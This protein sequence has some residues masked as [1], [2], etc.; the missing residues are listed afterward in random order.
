M[1][2]CLV[3]YGTFLDP[4]GV[5][6]GNS[7]RAY[8]L[9]RG[10][11]ERGVEVVHFY[12]SFLER[13][14]GADVR[15]PAGVTV[16][17]YTDAADLLAQIDRERPTAVLVGYWELLEHFPEGYHLPLIVDVVAPRILESLFEATR[18]LSAEAA[19]IV[20]LYRR[21]D[22]FLAGNE[23]Q[24]SFLVPWLILAGFRCAAGVPVAVVP[25]ST[26]VDEPPAGR[27]PGNDWRFVSGGV[28]WPWR[29]IEP[30]F[31]PL[32]AA[33]GRGPARLELF[34]GGYVYAGD[35]APRPAA[36]RWPAELVTVRELR[37]YAEMHAF[38]ASSCHV[39][40]ELAE[41]NLERE[42]SQSFRSADFLRHGLPLLCNRYLELARWIA[43]YDAGWVVDA[44][45]EVPAALD[46]IFAA[47]EAWRAKSENARRL[48]RE[49]LHYART[50]EPVLA[51]LTA[52]QRPERGPRALLG[53]P[54]AGPVPIMAAA[55]VE[56]AGRTLAARVPLRRRVRRGLRRAAAAVARAVLPRGGDAVLVVTRDDVFPANHGAAVKIDRTAS[57]LSA[58]VSAVYLATENRERY[59]RYR[60]GTVE[61]LRYPWPLRRVGPRGERVR[62][63][64]LAAGVPADDAFLYAARY[65]W[66]FA[67][68]ALYLALRHGAR[69]YQAEFPAYAKATLPARELLGGVTA[70]V[71]HNVE[72]Q[73]LADQNRDLP[74]RAA[75][76]LRGIELGLCEA[77]DFVV[78]VSARDRDTL[79]RD[80]VPPGNVRVIPHG[81]DLR[82][83]AAAVATRGE[84]RR[85]LGIG[86]AVPLLVFHGVYLYPPNLEA[87][88]VL[89]REILPRLHERGIRPKV[90]A[91]GPYPPAETPH[92]DI[93]FT[94][95]VPDVAPFLLDA[96]VA[97]VPLRRGGGTRM[98]VLDY[99]AAGLPV[100]ST[101]KGVEGLALR[102][103]EHALIRDDGA[104]FAA[105]VAELLDSPASRAALGAA[106]RR[107][108]EP[109]DWTAISARY[110]EA[111]RAVEEARAGPGGRGRLP[112]HE[113]ESA[114]DSNAPGQA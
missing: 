105:A 102:D 92:P 4:T 99:F 51:F 74:E 6:S 72:Y 49:R 84:A 103:G 32:V 21:A 93:L 107:F 41:Y 85:R 13:H 59:Y 80:G 46:R 77:A 73:R 65:D 98:K 42:F 29:R 17:S 75:A 18:D 91:I 114:V 76:W 35:E 33:L 39:G 25:I 12:P 47:P 64:L 23:R 68:R 55:P 36:P 50:I 57:G 43:E 48:A 54:S 90:L 5:M 44:P 38:L 40:V 89:A 87:M 96:D 52:P 9:A 109:L 2:T 112:A 100:V 97:V 71:E 28:S 31:D 22:L 14:A 10:L 79:V 11:V 67:A 34:S 108:V 88:H 19:R 24:R 60:N 86:P 45:G 69:R 20:E 110:L 61:A 16:R 83:F 101:A 94:G 82:A 78:A 66:S 26:E 7:V 81:V 58:H 56:P 113:P 53:P 111:Y 1:K 3:T 62:A 15:P 30:Y 8:Y 27:A 70:V 63:R 104:A 106:G 95:A 37:P